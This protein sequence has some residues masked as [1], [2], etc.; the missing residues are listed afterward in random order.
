MVCAGTATSKEQ[1]A[2]YAA[3]SVAT[4]KVGGQLCCGNESSFF[5]SLSACALTRS[6]SRFLISLSLSVSRLSRLSRFL[7]S[8][9]LSLSQ[10]S[11][12]LWRWWFALALVVCSGARS[13]WRS[14][15]LAL[16]VRS[17]AGGSLWRWFALALVRLWRWCTLWLVSFGAGFALALVCSGTCSLSGRFALALL[18]SGAVYI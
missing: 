13:L 8:F 4:S 3:M 2:L 9:S 18:R 12:L 11:G 14:F 6:V 16:V 7:V 1:H 5:L 17:S 10:R 15:A